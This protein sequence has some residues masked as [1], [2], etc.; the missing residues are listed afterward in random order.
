MTITLTL[1]YDLTREQWAVVDGVFQSMDGWLGYDQTANTPQWYGNESAERFVWASVEPS[2][3]LVEGNL[4]P[5]LWA[6]W[7]SVLCSRL[8]LALQ[9][10]IRDAEM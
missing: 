10:E 3:L 7:I 2:G 9:M 8:S 1:P 4:E 6:G 5:S